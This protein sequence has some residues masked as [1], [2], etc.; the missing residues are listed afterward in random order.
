MKFSAS[1]VAV[2]ATVVMAVQASPVHV[3]AVNT[4]QLAKLGLDQPITVTVK[5]DPL[6]RP[7]VTVDSD[8]EIPLLKPIVGGIENLVETFLGTLPLLPLL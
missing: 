5:I 3:P 2:L 6:S 1:A 4:A 7:H 8:P